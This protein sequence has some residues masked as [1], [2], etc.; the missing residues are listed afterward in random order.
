MSPRLAAPEEPRP[1]TAIRRTSISDMVQRFE[2]IDA[3]VKSP[4]SGLPIVPGISAKPVGFSKSQRSEKESVTNTTTSKPV[5]LVGLV[6]S[7]PPNN[8]TTKARMSP[9]ALTHSA[10]SNIPTPRHRRISTRTGDTP[11]IFPVK[12]PTLDDTTKEDVPRSPSPERP[13][14]GVGSLIAQWQK[15]SEEAA[16]SNVGPPKRGGFVAKRAGV[17]SGGAGRD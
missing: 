5:P 11:S 14:Q 9:I 8:D 12:K 4:T 17:I 7:V 15:K 13:Y 6:A 1:R 2:S 10:E 3:H 16:A